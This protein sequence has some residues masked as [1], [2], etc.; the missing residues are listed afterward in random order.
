M[1][2]LFFL[3]YIF[4]FL[5]DFFSSSVL[6]VEIQKLFLFWRHWNRFI[7]WKRCC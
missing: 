3:K 4:I 1:L 6:H 5:Y 2:E 7:Y